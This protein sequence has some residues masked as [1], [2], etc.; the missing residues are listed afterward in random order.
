MY[1]S[2]DWDSSAVLENY[3]REKAGSDYTI[4]TTGGLT[5]YSYNAGAAWVNGGIL[6]TIT[7]DAPLSADQIE[8]VATS[9]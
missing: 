7:G 5:I 8:H 6:Y 2:Q 1:K 3:V 4:S 9:L